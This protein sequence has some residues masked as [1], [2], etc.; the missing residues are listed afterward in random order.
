MYTVKLRLNLLRWQEWWCHQGTNA[1]VGPIIFI[2]CHGQTQFLHPRKMGKNYN[3]SQNLICLVLNDRACEVPGSIPGLMSQINKHACKTV[4]DV[5]PWIA[6]APHNKR[7]LANSIWVCFKVSPSRNNYIPVLQVLWFHFWHPSHWRPSCLGRTGCWQVMQLSLEVPFEVIFEDERYEKFCMAGLYGDRWS[8]DSWSVL[9]PFILKQIDMNRTA[10]LLI[11]KQHSVIRHCW[12]SYSN[13]IWLHFGNKRN[14]TL[15][16][17]RTSLTFS[18]AKGWDF[19]CKIVIFLP[20]A[21]SESAFN[22]L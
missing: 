20:H 2:I 14:N 3:D 5:N 10:C 21:L 17:L 7:K 19:C 22:L 11:W 16:Q 12:Y 13:Y 18:P 4:C 9:T 15:C 1:S 6:Q 8:N